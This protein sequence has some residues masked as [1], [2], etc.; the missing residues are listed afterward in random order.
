MS[1]MASSKSFSRDH[2][3]KGIVPLVLL[4]G[5]IIDS[6]LPAIFPGAFLGSNQ[7]IVSHL[8]LYFIIT[9]AFYMRNS[10][11]SLYSFIF[12]LLQDSYSTT[13]LGVYAALYFLVAYIILQ[14][15]RYF[16]RNAIVHFMLFIVAITIID[17]LVYFFYVRLG[18]VS[19][20]VEQY[21][22]TRLGPTL[23]F[24][25]ALAFFMY[26]PTR[27]LLGWLGYNE[28]IIF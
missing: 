1:S 3:I 17:Y 27:A 21:I 14:I 16:P 22:L 5:L 2:K 20:G 8:L 23:I 19:L 28:H 11:I 13:L 10:S 25:T 7:V 12:G 4:V 9:F 24:N 15:R 6:S 26:F 18:F